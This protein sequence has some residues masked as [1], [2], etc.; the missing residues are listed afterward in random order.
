MDIS[1]VGKDPEYLEEPDDDNNHDY[2]I[3]NGFDFVIHGDV[4]VDKPK[5]KTCDDQYD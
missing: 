2:Y 3:E 4:G 5:N 1:Q